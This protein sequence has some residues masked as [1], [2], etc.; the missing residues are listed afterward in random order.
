M[1]VNS[2]AVEL[3][4]KHTF[5][6]VIVGSGAAGL[7]LAL[8]LP[9]HMK[10]ALL[11]KDKLSEASTYY[12]QGGVAAVLDQDDSLEDHIH[13]TLV[14]GADLCERQAVTRCVEGAGAAVDF[15][16]QQGVEFTRDEA[17]SSALH[18]HQEG[19]HS[20]RR[21]IHHLDATGVS[22][23]SAL[24]KQARARE[25]IEVYEHFCAIDLITDCAPESALKKRVLGLY[26]LDVANDEILSFAAP[27]VALACGG[28]SRAYLYT[29]N[30]DVATGDGMA[31]AWRAGCRVANMEFNQFHPTCLFHEKARSFLLTEALRGEGAHLKL[32]SGERFMPRFDE[33]AELAPRD[34][35]ARAIDFEMKRLGIRHVWLDISHRDPEFVKGHFPTLYARLMELGI[36]MTAEPIPVVPAAH[37]TC[38][39]VMVNEHAQTDVAGLY[40]IGE[41]SY[42]GL[43]GANRLASNSLLECVVYGQAAAADMSLKMASSKA[44]E[45]IKPWDAS[46]V[47]DPDEEVVILQN[48]DELRHTMWNYVGIV[49]S[50]KRLARALS[51]IELLNSEI[52]EFYSSFRVSKNLIELRNL[53][54][55]AKMIVR[56]AQARKESR[57]LHATIDYPSMQDQASVTELMPPDFQ[58]KLCA[59]GE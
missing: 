17:D 6:V 31:M 53:V 9:A 43:H 4:A 35:V 28:A 52:E 57:G 12:A 46:Q 10:I 20:A 38:G 13:D 37:Y 15:L 41:T 1:C 56:C 29:S 49:R 2:T 27:F 16:L 44:S 54:C 51:R 7:T 40:A 36:D 39:G 32:P 18:L 48:W 5:D 23:S 45:A 11:A 34:V 25:N 59:L 22:I 21:I 42:T 33:R 58:S 47:T 24:T 3:S 55:V 30:P 14:A 26:A 50:D 19:G 8:S